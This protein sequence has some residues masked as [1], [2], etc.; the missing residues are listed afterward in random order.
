MI[1]VCLL[2]V[3]R[4]HNS[5]KSDFYNIITVLGLLFYFLFS[6][7][8]FF[9]PSVEKLELLSIIIL[10]LLIVMFSS[11]FYTLTIFALLAYLIC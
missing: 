6:R 3:L 7:F 11:I 8:L 9:E 5:S 2:Q 4:L 1:Y 10:S